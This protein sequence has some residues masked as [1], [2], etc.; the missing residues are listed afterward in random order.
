MPFYIEIHGFFFSA[1]TCSFI[2]VYLFQK[3]V[4]PS[5]SG[6]IGDGELNRLIYQE[7]MEDGG[8]GERPRPQPL[9]ALLCKAGFPRGLHLADFILVP[10]N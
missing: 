9:P 6:F 7:R 4:V 1:Q 3:R 2:H 10:P 8:V 5:P